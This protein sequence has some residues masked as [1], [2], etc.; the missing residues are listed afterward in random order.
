[1][2]NR[3]VRGRRN[4]RLATAERPERSMMS[5]TPEQVEA[6]HAFYTKRALAV[7][8]VA[9]LGFFSRAAWKCPARRILQHYNEHISTNH[10]DVGVGTGYFVDHCQFGSPSP[11]IALMDLN[12]NCLEVASRRIARFSPE[13]YR[14]NVLGPI[15]LDAPKFD[16]IALNYVL[17]C[18]PGEMTAKGAAFEHLQALLNPGGVV[19]G[20]TLLHDGVHRNWLARKVMDRNNKHGIFSNVDDSLDG[21][22]SVLSQH[23]TDST[24]N[25]VG[26]VGI[27]AGRLVAPTH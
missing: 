26:C 18:V 21:L 3:G 5:A 23:L 16:S 10:L 27:F 7:Y 8:D 17:H 12:T 13:V 22:R 4:Y 14:A 25:V 11:R 1:M 20:A 19:F 9:I 2:V 24:V 6:G 15:R